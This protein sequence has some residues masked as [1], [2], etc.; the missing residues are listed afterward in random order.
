MPNLREIGAGL[1]IGFTH[2]LS[3]LSFTHDDP[4]CRSHCQIMPLT[5]DAPIARFAS[6][7]PYFAIV[8][9]S[10]RHRTRLGRWL[11]A[12]QQ[13]R[14]KHKHQRNRLDLDDLPFLPAVRL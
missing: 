13:V 11:R 12:G 8:V 14:D 10:N 5:I 3:F 9:G 2:S 6:V 1:A 7:A 4:A